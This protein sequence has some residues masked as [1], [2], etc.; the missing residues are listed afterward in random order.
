MARGRRGAPARGVAD[1]RVAR[2][3][4]AADRL[5]D[6]KPPADTQP[7]RLARLARMRWKMELDYKQLKGELGLDHYEGRSWLGWYHHTALVTAA[8]G[9]LTLGAPS[10]FS[11]AVGLTLPKAVLL[12]QPIFKCWTGRCQTCQQASDLARLP[13]LT[14]H[15]KMNKPNK[16]LLA[17]ADP[18]RKRELRIFS[19][20]SARAPAI[21]PIA[22]GRSECLTLTDTAPL[23]GN[24]YRRIRRSVSADITAALRSY[25]SE[26][27]HHH[28]TLEAVCFAGRGTIWGCEYIYEVCIRA[29]WHPRSTN[30][31]GRGPLGRT[32]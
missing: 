3:P 28:D 32:P 10:P 26:P 22:P 20:L 1:R 4:R 13:L 5:L 16:A 23:R 2:G 7:E 27:D 18:R 19:L 12:M 30:H 14:H 9:F 11:P 6:L 15:D 31:I 8:H 29:R 21:S 25:L 24:T 17:G